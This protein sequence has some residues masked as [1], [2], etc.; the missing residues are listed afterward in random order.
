METSGPAGQSV[1]RQIVQNN[2]NNNNSD[3]NVA[4]EQTE[5]GLKKMNS[6]LQVHKKEA[7]S[8]QPQGSCSKH[9]QFLQ[10]NWTCWRSDS[11]H[12][13]R[14]RLE[15]NLA[16]VSGNGKEESGSK[17]QRKVFVFVTGAQQSGSSAALGG[18]LPG[19]VLGRKHELT[20]PPA[21]LHVFFVLAIRGLSKSHIRPSG[22]AV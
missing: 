11:L 5:F 12:H 10:R 1:Q 3:D 4:I 7:E 6:L 22:G 14:T 18:F 17:V 15:K 16:G 9:S 21:I 8:R 19:K 2:N 20:P 13:S